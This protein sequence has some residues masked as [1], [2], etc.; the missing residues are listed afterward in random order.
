MSTESADQ[1]TPDQEAAPAIPQA[2]TPRPV[3]GDA[4][5]AGGSAGVQQGVA[6]V[7]PCKNEQERIGATVRGAK[8]I[9][10]VDLV[11]V[12][13][14]G[15]DDDTQGAARAA[16]AVLVRHTQNRGKAA[17]ME[18]GAKIVAM[19]DRPDF[20]ARL[21]L[22]IDGDLSESAV[23]TAPLV[24]PV[25]EGAA[26]VSIANLPV[27]EGA[28]GRGFVVGA[29]RKAITSMTGWTPKQPLSGMRC[30]TREAFDAAVPLARGWGVETAMTID[31]LRKGYVAVEIPCDIQHR[32]SA[33]DFAG[34]MHR[35]EQ[36]RDVQLAV[37]ARQIKRIFGH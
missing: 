36:Y 28:G 2:K 15:S 9:P 20:P 7:I 31:L 17:A 35:A 21:L 37:A 12:V 27:Q 6:V 24:P 14:D 29:A 18:T 10:G 8:A 11:V 3:T 1:V 5:G 19:R 16:G 34:Q 33:N 26:D 30:L 23:N 22:F 4:G 32:A 25:L 13:D